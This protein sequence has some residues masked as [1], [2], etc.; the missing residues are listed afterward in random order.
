MSLRIG[1]AA[2][3]TAVLLLGGTAAR[4]EMYSFESA[5]G[6]R[7]FYA[8][9]LRYDHEK[10]L[11][12]VRKPDGREITFPMSALNEESR[13]Y[14]DGQKELLAA[15]RRLKV[16]LAGQWGD[17]NVAKAATSKTITSQRLYTVEISNYGRLPLTDLEVTYDVHLFRDDGKGGSRSVR[18][19][20]ETITYLSTSVDHERRLEPVTLSQTVPLSVASGGLSGGG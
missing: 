19:S 11:V 6:K 9:L 3:C 10:M 2:A 18:S 7:S 4:A 8:E 17:R 20:T 1:L 15:R 14:V 12:T 16:E 5:D 13:E